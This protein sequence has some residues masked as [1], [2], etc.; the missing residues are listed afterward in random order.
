MVLPD[1]RPLVELPKLGQHH[2][3]LD[4]IQTK[5]PADDLVEILGLGA[6]VAQNPQPFGAL[7]VLADHQATIARTAEVFG[8]EK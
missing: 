8:R 2:R 4:R 6:V 1:S 5:I 3:G 7:S